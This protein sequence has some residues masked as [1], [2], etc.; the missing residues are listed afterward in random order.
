MG[1]ATAREGEGGGVQEDRGS[2]WVH[3]RAWFGQRMAGGDEFGGGE[4]GCLRGNRR[5]RRRLEAPRSNSFDG[6][7]AGGDA[8]LL[9][10]SGQ[11]GGVQNSVLGGSHAVQ[12]R[13]LGG[14]HG[15]RGIAS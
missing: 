9:S 2:P 3:Q 13:L 11:H 10:T 4:L 15:E 5:W 8:D 6:E 1:G 7:A 12:G 14:V